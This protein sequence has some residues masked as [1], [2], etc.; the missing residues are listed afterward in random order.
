MHLEV[1]ILLIA[2]LP[3]LLWTLPIHIRARNIA[4]VSLAL[5]LLFVG[6][7]RGVNAVRIIS[8]QIPLTYTTC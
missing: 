4:I 6:L 1:L 2:P 5:N 3:L 7:V 8:V